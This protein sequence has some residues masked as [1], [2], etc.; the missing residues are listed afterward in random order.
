MCRCVLSQM[1]TI[2]VDTKVLQGG[3][4]C[5]QS[6]F[7][8]LPSVTPEE[9][10]LT[11]TAGAIAGV[12]ACCVI[13]ISPSLPLQTL[14]VHVCG[15]P[16]C[17]TDNCSVWWCKQWWTLCEWIVFSSSS[18]GMLVRVSPPYLFDVVGSCVGQTSCSGVV[19]V[20]S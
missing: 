7:S 4:W 19:P 20:N 3:L 16:R 17:V 14:C 5:R 18:K 1:T 8:S 10:S 12:A 6:H 9:T 2:V 11:P 13:R 15:E